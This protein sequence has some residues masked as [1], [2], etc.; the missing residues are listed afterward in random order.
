[1]CPSIYNGCVIDDDIAVAL[2]EFRKGL[3]EAR[4][5]A[6]VLLDSFMTELG[7]LSTPKEKGSATIGTPSLDNEV[8]WEAVEE[9]EDGN[10]IVIFYDYLG[11]IWNGTSFDPRPPSSYIDPNNATH[12]HCI[13][14]IDT[15][16]QIDPTY[17]V[18][19]C[20]PIWITP[21]EIQALVTANLVSTG[22][23]LPDPTPGIKLT[24][25]KGSPLP[26]SESTAND[27]SRV[28][29]MTSYQDVMKAFDIPVIEDTTSA[30]EFLQSLGEDFVVINERLLLVEGTNL[31]GVRALYTALGKDLDLL[32]QHL[33]LMVDRPTSIYLVVTQNVSIP[34]SEMICGQLQTFQ[35]IVEKYLASDK[36][37]PFLAKENSIPVESLNP[38]LF[39][40]V[41][42]YASTQNYQR[43]NRFGIPTEYN[44]YIFAGTDAVD[45]PYLVVQPPKVSTV[46]DP[47]LLDK[48][49]LTD[50]EIV[51]LLETTTP[52]IKIPSEVTV[53]DLN[54]T[55]L[56]TLSKVK[57]TLANGLSTK[58]KGP[59]AAGDVVDMEKTYGDKNRTKELTTRG[60]ACARQ[61]SLFP[62]IPDLPNVPF[63]NLPNP[64]KKIESLFGAISSAV[65]ASIDTFDSIWKSVKKLLNP[66]L[67]KFQNL[68]SF[69][70]NLF[71]NDLAKCALGVGQKLTGFPN[72]GGGGVNPTVGGLGGGPTPSLGGIPVPLDLFKK[73]MGQLSTKVNEIITRSFEGVMKAIGY[74][75]CMAQ[76][77]LSSMTNAVGYGT[78]L[79]P[80]VNGKN[81]NDL[82]PVKGVQDVINANEDLTND[83]LSLPQ[84]ANLPTSD[85]LTSKVADVEKF[86]GRL[87]EFAVT[88]SQEL[89]RGISN[90][91]DELWKSFDSK[92][93]LLDKFDEAVRS[94]GTDFQSTSLTG[95]LEQ[96]RQQGCAP[97]SVGMF[98][99]IITQL[100]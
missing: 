92:M 52:G 32:K 97:P 5:E 42:V 19:L 78:S 51:E 85:Q 61:S 68:N 50:A 26:D 55:L 15:N 65:N 90:I 80:C 46:E 71:K 2:S 4:V 43:L 40:P 94:L 88:T 47:S 77:L 1:M 16:A 38:Y 30:R 89:T 27:I 13:I 28:F 37:I 70:E 22:S 82:C 56:N 20:L 11:P 64:A 29:G 3:E 87:N 67:N 73:A 53:D 81:P 96:Q 34:R 48:L 31:V 69:A 75:L 79:I 36:N 25:G 57:T 35:T 39:W 62:D 66:I 21:I 44:E 23:G 99:D 74:P 14:P 8:K 45:V 12:I 72:L 95:D 9:G 18:N 10:S 86:T 91:V 58:A 100:L 17:P 98:S 84:T 7:E 60:K 83:L 93:T 33:T 49:Q 24:G 63:P 76:T 41:D 54:S 59:I 6:E